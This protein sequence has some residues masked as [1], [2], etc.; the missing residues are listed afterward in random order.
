[1]WLNML[2]KFDPL[3]A[4]TNLFSDVNMLIIA[5]GGSELTINEQLILPSILDV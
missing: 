3:N 4:T 5:N 1:M 2:E